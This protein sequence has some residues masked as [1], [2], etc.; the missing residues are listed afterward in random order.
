MTLT[1]LYRQLDNPIPDDWHA[2]VH[3]L[4]EAYSTDHECSHPVGLC[5]V[6]DPS[7]LKTANWEGDDYPATLDFILVED[8]Y[9]R[10]GVAMAL[11][12]ACRQ[13]WKNLVLTNAVSAVGEAFLAQ[14]A[15]EE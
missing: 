10:Q 9:R 5:W 13:R 15:S 8:H 7:I 6:S 12:Q 2:G 11:V 14:V 1:F 3:W 4:V